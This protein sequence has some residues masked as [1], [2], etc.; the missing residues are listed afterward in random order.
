MSSVVLSGS[1]SDPRSER[2]VARVDEVYEVQLQVAKLTSDVEPI[3][4]DISDMKT[5]LRRIDGK[6]DAVDARLGGRID[7]IVTRPHKLEKDMTTQFGQLKVVMLGL[8]V[9]QA[10]NLLLI[11]IAKSL[12][13]L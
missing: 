5:D 13:W 11:I 3:K 6:L 9:G 8:Y 7:A 2:R 4:T 12:E 1:E 10:A